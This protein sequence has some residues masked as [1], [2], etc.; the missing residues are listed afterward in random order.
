MN[1]SFKKTEK[2]KSQSTTSSAINSI[3][4]IVKGT[5][6][7]GQVNSETDIRIDG[8]IEG[9]IDCKAK[10]IIGESGSVI[11]DIVCQNATIEGSFKG[12]IQVTDEMIVTTTGKIDGEMS[13]KKLKV[14]PGA[15]FDVT[16]CK[17]GV[18]GKL[19]SSSTMKKAKIASLVN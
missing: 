6:I 12:M 10:V 2:V 14:S 8:V 9:N 19:R 3:N 11:G 7:R 1:M 18:E 4:S 5:S 16:N 15:T 17:V 13:A